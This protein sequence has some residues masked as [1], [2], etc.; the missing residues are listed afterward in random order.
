MA[1]TFAW[2]RLTCQIKLKLELMD[3][4]RQRQVSYDFFLA[5]EIAFAFSWSTVCV[6]FVFS[7]C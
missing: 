4:S 5:K 3:N 2:K 7:R 6:F 1:A